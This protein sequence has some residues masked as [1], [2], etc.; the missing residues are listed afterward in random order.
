MPGSLNLPY[1]R[2]FDAEGGLLPPP[3]LRAAFEAAGLD[4]GK[5][6]V[7]TCGSGVSACVL[8][9]ALAVAGGAEGAV[10]DGSWTEW[11][12]REDTPVAV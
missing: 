1:D 12:G 8:T 3:A 6:A 9:L 2:L 4:P 11:G 10:Y 7:T 5:P